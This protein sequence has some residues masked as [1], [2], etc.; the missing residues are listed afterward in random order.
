ML[1][2]ILYL[3]QAK[4]TLDVPIILDAILV[5]GDSIFCATGITT[6]DLVK[7]I[8]ILQDSFSSETLITH[9]STGIKKVVKSKVKNNDEVAF[10]PPVTGG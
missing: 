1:N 10:F 2:L 5:S 7:G 4:V 6:G 8:N 9:K 3:I